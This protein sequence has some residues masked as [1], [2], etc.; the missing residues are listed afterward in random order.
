V[1]APFSPLDTALTDR[2]FGTDLSRDEVV[3]AATAASKSGQLAKSL[4]LLDRALSSRA[5]DPD[6][7]YARALTLLDWGR[8][9]EALAGLLAAKEAGLSSFGLFIN[10]S[11]VCHA[12]GLTEEAEQ[13]ALQAMAVDSGQSAGHFCLAVVRQATKR[14]A[15]AIE[16]YERGYALAPDRVDALWEIVS[17]R[18]DQ[19][20]ARRG[21]NDARRAISIH[22]ADHAKSWAL[23]GSALALQRRWDDAMAAFERAE[24]IEATSGM[25]GETFAM[26]GFQLLWSGQLDRAIDLYRHYLPSSTNPS[27]HAHLGLVLLTAGRLRDG[28]PLYEFRWMYDRLLTTRPRLGRPEWRG[29]DL[30]GKRLLLWAEQGVGDIVQFVRM[31]RLLKAKGACVLLHVPERL[32]DFARC[33]DSVERVVSDP[34]EFAGDFDYHLSLMSAPG[35]LDIDLDSIPADVPYLTVDAEREKRWKERVGN[36]GSLTV[37]LAWAGNPTHEHDKFRSIPLAKLAPLFGVEGVRFFSLQKERRA[38]D[39]CALPPGAQMVDLAPELIDFR[40][41]AAAI[42]AM[43]LVI[44]VDTA[45]VHI[46]GAV[47]TPAWVMLQTPPDFRWLMDGDSSPWYPTLRLFRQN[48]GG[49]WDEVIESVRGALTTV[50]AAWTSE[51]MTPPAALYARSDERVRGIGA[52]T[53]DPMCGITDT[54]YGIVQYI[55]REEA[56]AQ[57]LE[58]YGEWLQSQLDLI[59]GNIGPGS[60]VIEAGSGVGVHTL[61]L[62]R[63]VGP[64]GSVFAYEPDDRRFRILLQNLQINKVRDQVTPLQRRLAGPSPSL[65]AEDGDGHN[66]RGCDTVD[67]LALNRLHLLKINCATSEDILEGAR[68][69]LR[70][71]RPIVLAACE[72]E[73]ACALA[74]KMDCVGYRCLQSDTPYFS[75]TNHAGR[76]E[77]VFQG[78]TKVTM[79]CVPEETQSAPDEAEPVSAFAVQL[80][81]DKAYGASNTAELKAVRVGFDVSMQSGSRSLERGDGGAAETAFRDAVRIQDTSAQAWNG[82]GVAL[83]L[84]DRHADAQQVLRRACELEDGGE[85]C[86]AFVNLANSLAAEG[87]LQDAIAL[88]RRQLPEHPR[89]QG[90]HNYAFALLTVG[91]FTEGWRHYEFRWLVE[92]LRSLRPR[93]PRPPWAGQDLRGK[94]ILLHCEQGLGDTIQFVRYGALL[95]ALGAR[96]ILSVQS[97]LAELA[98]GFANV[99]MIVGDTKG[100]TFDY[101]VPLLSLPRIFGTEVSSIPAN[102]PYITSDP[103]RRIRWAECLGPDGGPKVGVVWAGSRAHARD[104]SR[105]LPFGALGNVLAIEGI[106]FYALQKSEESGPGKFALLNKNLVDLGP[107]LGDFA[108]TAAAIAEM[109]LMLCVDTSVAHLAAALGKPV[110]LI[111]PHPADFRWL[112]ERDDSPWYPTVRLFRQSRRDDWSDVVERVRTA[113]EHWVKESPSRTLVPVSRSAEP[114]TNAALP[115]IGPEHINAGHRPGLTAVAETRAGTLQY[116]P[117]EPIVGDSIG[118]YGEYLQAEIDLLARFIRP[119]ATILEVSA[120][121]GAHAVPLG[122]MIGESGRLWVHE[123]RPVP[124][125]ILRQNLAANGLR[126]VT[127]LADS[128][129]PRP[130]RALIEDATGA[131]NIDELDLQRLDCL[132]VG[133][134]S[135]TIEVLTGATETVWR[136]RPLLFLSLTGEETFNLIKDRVREFG[137]RC[138]RMKTPFFNAQNFNRRDTDIFR[139]RTALSLLA[140]PEESDVEVI[141]DGCSEVL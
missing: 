128:G 13:N 127:V 49:E 35:A 121:V 125:E 102:I 93:Y 116:S 110:W 120:G 124:R 96:V 32:K 62:A 78:R 103:E 66:V 89:P 44:A 12:S 41:T 131:A 94:S 6:L 24:A 79:L 33:F 29:Q 61:E 98:R 113:L 108:D 104:R 76:T 100:V 68:D 25:P 132:K 82:L 36:N 48:R 38:E 90:H 85:V 109:D 46:A 50:A 39:T 84:Q 69:T 99:D 14:Y 11:Q 53:V 91:E 97:E 140:V 2:T 19:D 9:R 106:R 31:A 73:H 95:K 60:V 70:R 54:R 57:S 81:T 42:E 56:L 58:L 52:R 134:A 139:G 74:K 67:D 16:S 1:T 111:L 65:A 20:D 34:S 5:R 75:P 64:T 126:Q 122:R 71:L 137:Y 63:R 59:A 15:D 87:K 105:S 130:D 112:E 37:G 135:D 43:D 21:E 123:S 129:D 133:Q 18:L 136:L 138:W 10:L 80:R 26:H 30:M 118:W 3:A 114:P 92:P 119:G 72:G 101:Y 28:W 27:A 8:M 77:D 40:D 86:D 83:A 88:Y 22:G 141:F 115:W 7:I 4:A 51:H 23:L 117:D 45:I 107:R 17:C 47:A 55:R